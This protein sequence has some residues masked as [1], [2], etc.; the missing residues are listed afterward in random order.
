MVSTIIIL[1][2]FL[3]DYQHSIL[4]H[5]YH[6]PWLGISSAPLHSDRIPAPPRLTS[7]ACKSF[8]FE[9]GPLHG[10][11]ALC[12][13][14][15]VSCPTTPAAMMQCMIAQQSRSDPKAYPQPGRMVSVEQVIGVSILE[16]KQNYDTCWNKGYLIS[17]LLKQRS[18]ELQNVQYKSCWIQ[19]LLKSSLLNTK[20]VKFKIPQPKNC[21]CW[22]LFFIR[23]FES[24]N[25]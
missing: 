19:G 16:S 17:R 18:V 12:Q 20:I 25:F 4:H 9:T 13:Q 24:K 8:S 3:H 5:G 7:F 23:V 15:Q 11:R 22:T 10:G 21:C 6:P 14:L 2:T 1:T